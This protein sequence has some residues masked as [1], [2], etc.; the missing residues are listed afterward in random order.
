MCTV[1]KEEVPGKSFQWAYMYRDT[2]E[3]DYQ[4][5]CMDLFITKYT[6]DGSSLFCFNFWPSERAYII[7]S[8]TQIAKHTQYSLLLPVFSSVAVAFSSAPLSQRKQRSP[9]RPLLCIQP[10]EQDSCCS[11][12]H[13]YHVDEFLKRL[14]FNSRG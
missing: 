7:S 4:G 2:S 14:T 11:V 13:D 12:C 5:S 8:A 6:R 9:P 1:D 3:V 10:R